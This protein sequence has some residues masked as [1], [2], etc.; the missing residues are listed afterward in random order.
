MV[1]RFSVKLFAAVMAVWAAWSLGGL[2]VRLKEA[3]LREASLRSGLRSTEAA[4]AELS[5]KDIETL[6]REMGYVFRGD[7]VFFDGG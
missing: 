4:I 6:L 1:K 7:V 5:E 2:S 3:S